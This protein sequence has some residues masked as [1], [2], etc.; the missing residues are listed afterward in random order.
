M[1]GKFNHKKSDLSGYHLTKWDRYVFHLEQ[2][3][4]FLG[5]TA[6]P[7]YIEHSA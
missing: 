7:G 1:A 6:A 2:I 4:L 5:F 3:S